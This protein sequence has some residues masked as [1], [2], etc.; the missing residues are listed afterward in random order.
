MLQK[1]V[2]Q[3]IMIIEENSRNVNSMKFTLKSIQVQVGKSK[4]LTINKFRIF[5][6][7]GRSLYTIRLYVSNLKIDQ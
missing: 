5:L 7:N 4:S 3:T 2:I 1:L 6:F